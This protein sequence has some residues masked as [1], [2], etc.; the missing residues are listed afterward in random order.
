MVFR[1]LIKNLSDREIMEKKSNKYHLTLQ[2]NQYANGEDEPKK[3]WN[4]I[5]VIMM[6]SLTSLSGLKPKTLLEMKHRL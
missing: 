6:R 1:L 3:N 2:L 5:L 4:S